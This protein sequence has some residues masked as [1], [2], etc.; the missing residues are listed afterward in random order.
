MA[1]GEKKLGRIRQCVSSPVF[2]L[3]A[4]SVVYAIPSHI[5]NGRIWLEWIPTSL[6][7]LGRPLT[8]LA[9]PPISTTLIVGG[10]SL[11]IMASSADLVSNT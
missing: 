5:T 9:E 7:W 8:A 3:S 10:N 4:I 6:S 2:W 11:V 1:K